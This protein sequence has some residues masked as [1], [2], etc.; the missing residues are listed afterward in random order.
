MHLTTRETKHFIGHFSSFI[1][2]VSDSE[3]RGQ[4]TEMSSSTYESHL[5]A[6]GAQKP[7]A[8]QSMT[9]GPHNLAEVLESSLSFL[10][11]VNQIYFSGDTRT[12]HMG[13]LDSQTFLINNYY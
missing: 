9:I 11:F 6:H 8:R 13:I 12:V 1:R 4:S 5:K 10:S 2:A 7:C 3:G